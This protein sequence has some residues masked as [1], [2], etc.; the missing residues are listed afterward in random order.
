M[1]TLHETLRNKVIRI[2]ISSTFEDM[3]K[4]RDILQQK[5]YPYLVKL[6][7]PRGWQIDFVDLRW[8]ISK[9][10][11]VQQKTMHICL[12][13]LERCKKV[14]PRP[15][16]LILQ[17]QRYGW[18]PLP[19]LIEEQHWN[20]LLQLA[21]KRGVDQLLT[22]WYRRDTNNDPISYELRGKNEFPNEHYNTDYTRYEHEVEKPLHALMVEY[23]AAN[24]DMTDEEKVMFSASATE[25]EISHGALSKHVE[26]QQVAA[27]IRTVMGIDESLS[28]E[29][30]LDIPDHRQYA[31][32]AISNLKQKIKERLANEESSLCEYSVSYNEYH[33]DKYLLTVEDKLKCLLKHLVENEMNEY[34]RERKSSWEEEVIRQEEFV[35]LRT[36]FFCGRSEIVN[37]MVKFPSL[38]LKDRLFCLE[39]LSGT[40]KSSVMGKVYI[41]LTRTEEYIVL[42]RSVGEGGSTSG[43]AILTSILQELYHKHKIEGLKEDE[44]VKKSYGELVETVNHLMYTYKGQKIVLMIDAIDQLPKNDPM[45]SFDWLPLDAKGNVCVLVSRI[46]D[47]QSNSL[48]THSTRTLDS[49]EAEG[50][51]NIRSYT[52][53]D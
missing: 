33:S 43:Q 7:A 1:N 40:G 17:G 52:I 8:G 19:E 45:R 38:S 30:L 18:C 37:E 11:G 22:K 9:E 10:A 53:I 31:Q 27:Y 6:C 23:V 47:G 39:G 5:V 42:I 16:F 49:M 50:I 25:Q 41:E 3:R 12:Q 26:P 28:V 32:V 44:W 36:Q 29:P 24:A 20:S 13:E 51:K 14:S 21:V 15:N 2:F 48:P 35:R 34:E 46:V 4:E